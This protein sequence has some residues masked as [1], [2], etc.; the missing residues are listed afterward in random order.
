MKKTLR[1]LAMLMI[2]SALTFSFSSC[3]DDPVEPANNEQQGGGSHG[4]EEPDDEDNIFANTSWISSLQNSTVYQG[5]NMNISYDVS[6]DFNDA[7]SGEIYMIVSAEVPA[8]PA[9]NQTIDQ[10]WNFNYTVNGNKILLTL[11][12]DG[13]T[14]SEPEELIYNPEDQTI[15]WDQNDEDFSQMFGTDFMIFTKVQ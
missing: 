10:S 7:T 1:L 13:E 15:S 12:E 8:Y 2:V 9:A 5:I 11:I 3:E 4:G 6:L 14:S